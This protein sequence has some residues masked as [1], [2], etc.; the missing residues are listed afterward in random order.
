VP[1]SLGVAAASA[2]YTE[3][4]FSFYTVL[5]VIDCW[6]YIRQAVFLFTKASSKWSH[7]FDIFLQ[8]AYVCLQNGS[9]SDAAKV[10]DIIML[11]VRLLLK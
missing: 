11:H 2:V 1:I 10:R 6:Q 9:K 8:N 5:I 3:V 4:F 7:K